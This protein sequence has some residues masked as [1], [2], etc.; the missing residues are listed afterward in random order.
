MYG[1]RK[2]K[3][4]EFANLTTC[5][6]PFIANMIPFSYES[7]TLPFC[8]LLQWIN[9]FNYSKKITNDAYKSGL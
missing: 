9:L 8:P 7:P 2:K 6:N 5:W 4:E 1:K 3:M